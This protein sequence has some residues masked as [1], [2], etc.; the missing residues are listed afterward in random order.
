MPPAPAPVAEPEPKEIP[1][2][3]GPPP[4]KNPYFKSLGHPTEHTPATSPPAAQSTNP[5]H[6]LAQQ[7]RQE[8]VKP[9]FTGAGPLERKT[10]ARPGDDYDCSAAGSKFDS[11]DNEEERR[12]G[13]STKQLA[14]ILFGTMTPPRPLNAMDEEKSPSKQQP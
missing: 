10:R 1:S 2:P 8:P 5:F 4:S 7:D 14:S 12:G 11:S 6:R 3:E 13:A 9:T